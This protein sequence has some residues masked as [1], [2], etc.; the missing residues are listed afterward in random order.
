MLVNY[1]LKTLQ[2]PLRFGIHLLV[3]YT[4]TF[5]AFS[6]VIVCVARDPGPVAVEERGRDDDGRM[7]LTEA[8]MAP[9]DHNDDL[10]AP[11]KFCHK[12]WAAKPERAHHC[13]IC[14]RCVLKMDHHCLWLASKCIGHR[15]YPAFVHFL[16]SIT[17]LALYIAVIS[18]SALWFAF[19][20]PMAIDITTPVHELFLSFAGIV[21]TLVIGSF[22]L[23]HVYLISTNQTT[24]ENLSPFLLLRYLPPLNMSRNDN[25]E[26]LDEDRMSH[27]QRRTVRDAH[28]QIRIYD[29]GWRKNW[30]Q[31]FGW[32]GKYGWVYRLLCGGGGKGDGRTFPRNPRSDEMLARLASELVRL[33]KDI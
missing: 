15:T 17:L 29:V 23:Y 6:S 12:C 11:G 31:V 27:G 19:N 16:C 25:P 18:A 28:Q 10:S 8:L 1:H 22:L 21:F 32:N 4:L 30:T 7:D 24:L 13:S 20:N 9:H 14:G 33:D 5:C 3:T 2:S 26:P